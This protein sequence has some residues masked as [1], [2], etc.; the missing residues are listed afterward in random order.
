MIEQ[1]YICSPHSISFDFNDCAHKR[2]NVGVSLSGKL[3]DSKS[4]LRGS[5]PCTGVSTHSVLSKR[6][7][8]R[9]RCLNMCKKEKQTLAEMFKGYSEE[10]LAQMQAEMHQEYQKIYEELGGPVG[11]EIF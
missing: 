2:T 10:E 7:S 1:N 8:E 3:S 5:N 9:K 6:R 4:G 11:R